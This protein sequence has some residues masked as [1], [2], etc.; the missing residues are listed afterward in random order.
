MTAQSPQQQ[1]CL[2]LLSF[3][4]QGDS[5]KT[6]FLGMS[7]TKS[8]ATAG[9]WVLLAL[10]LVFL[11]TTIFFGVK[12]SSARRKAFKSSSEMELK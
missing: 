9:G 10:A 4:A 7:L 1:P 12:F 5:D 11:I 8:Q 3:P 2:S 6:D